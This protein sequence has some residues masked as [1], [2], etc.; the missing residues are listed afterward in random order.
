MFA[1]DI[2]YSKELQKK[3]LP[4]LTE[5]MKMREYHKLPCNLFD[6]DKYVAH[7]RTLN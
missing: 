2:E 3:H 7:I 5:R 4:F 1:I 6:E